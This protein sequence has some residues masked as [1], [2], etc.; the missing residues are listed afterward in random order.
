MHILHVSAEC[1]PAAKVGGLGDVAGALPKY[2]NQAGVTASLVMPHYHNKFF[3]EHIWDIVHEGEFKL[4]AALHPYEIRKE[5]TNALGFDLFITDIPGLLKEE[6]PYG[7]SNDMQRHLGFQV[8]VV[9]WLSQRQDRPNVIHCHDHPTGLIPFMMNYCYPYNHLKEIKTVFTIHSGQYQGIFGMDNLHLIPYF[10]D[11]KRGMLEWNDAINSMACAIKCC[12]KF[13]TVS[14][15]YLN[16]LQ[17]SALG[18]E[19]LIKDE[20]QKSKG[21]LNGID[22]D[23]W[24]PETDNWIETGYTASN[25]SRGKSENKIALCHSFHLNPDKP[26]VIFIGRLVGDK[27]GDL[28]ADSVR[29][30]VLRQNRALNFLVLGSGVN[31][32]EDA[33][34]ALKAAMPENFNCYIGYHEKLAHLMYAGADFILMPSRV[35]PCGLNQLYALRY[36]TIPI[37]RSTGGLIDTVSDI[38]NPDGFGIRFEQE[39]VAAIDVAVERALTLYYDEERVTAVRK[40]IMAFDHSWDQAAQEYIDLYESMK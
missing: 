30:A 22:A 28:L 8:C 2:L 12:W 31:E 20:R 34:N 39:S 6:L 7:Y 4:G 35:E 40:K 33:L 27:G 10:D 17:Q 24:N 37:V 23:I 29:Q 32:Y 25:V 11:W 38:S 36:G 18:I 26:L 3:R 15:S 5:S 19:S 9:D 14:P 1:Y 21:I 13:T 16:E